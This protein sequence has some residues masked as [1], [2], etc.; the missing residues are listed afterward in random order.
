MTRPI[1]V[2][3]AAVN[4]ALDGY[5]GDIKNGISR[6][7]AQPVARAK[8]LQAWERTVTG[9]AQEQAYRNSMAVTHG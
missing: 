1:D 3:E 5:Y 4:A 7:D 9:Q 6:R 2:M 8:I